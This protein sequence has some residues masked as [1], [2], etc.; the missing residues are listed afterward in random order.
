MA[1]GY[2]NPRLG[3]EWRFCEGRRCKRLRAND[4]FS[5]SRRA[6]YF[7]DRLSQRAPAVIVPAASENPHMSQRL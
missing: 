3:V 4:L 2:E 1:A 5:A 7:A 6:D